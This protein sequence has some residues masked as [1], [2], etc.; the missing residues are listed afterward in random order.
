[1]A[2]RLVEK[3]SGKP[4]ALKLVLTEEQAV[5]AKILC[6]SI[7]SLPPKVR[8]FHPWVFLQKC[9]SGGLPADDALRIL[10]GIKDR[11]PEIREVWAYA[12][13]VLK[14]EY[15]QYRIDL[16]LKEHEERKRE[17]ARIGEILGQMARG[18]GS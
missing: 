4:K 6:G 5:R 7:E 11:W 10:V 16:E 18:G 1:M 15:Q 14:R 8:K 17:P 2:R 13:E 3:V 9:V 12:Q